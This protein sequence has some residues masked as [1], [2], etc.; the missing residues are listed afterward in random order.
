MSNHTTLKQAAQLAK[1][2]PASAYDMIEKTAFP[3]IEMSEE[4]IAKVVKAVAKGP[5]KLGYDLTVEKL[6]DYFR[7]YGATTIEIRGPEDMV[8]M[9]IKPMTP[10]YFGGYG[11]NPRPLSLKGMETAADDLRDCLETAKNIWRAAN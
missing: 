10:G 9:R 4:V 3:K 5:A 6:P 2:D 8:S 7:H 11:F 1:T